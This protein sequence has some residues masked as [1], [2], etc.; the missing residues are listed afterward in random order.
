MAL[1]KKYH[2]IYKYIAVFEPD[3]EIGGYTVTIPELPGCIS[4]GDTFEDAL[5]NIK[6]A[7]E[8]YMEVMKDKIKE[9]SSATSPILV[10]P[11]EIK[12]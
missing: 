1:A 10:A 4:E 9:S 12:V 2:K 6:E 3:K 11:I 5:V 7:A 8:L